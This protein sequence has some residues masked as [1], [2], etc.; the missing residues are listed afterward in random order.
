MVVKSKSELG[1]K[2]GKG[3]A[4]SGDKEPLMFQSI[5]SES[6]LKDSLEEKGLERIFEKNKIKI[7]G[8]ISNKVEKRKVL[9]LLNGL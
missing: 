2:F 4:S 6:S 9:G 3:E 8:Q 5:N 1:K 7:L